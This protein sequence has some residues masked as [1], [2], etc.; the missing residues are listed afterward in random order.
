MDRDQI[1][2]QAEIVFQEFIVEEYKEDEEAEEG[3]ED[4]N[5][6]VFNVYN[7]ADCVYIK[8]S[9][10]I[11]ESNLITI[12]NIDNCGDIGIGNV[13]CRLIDV[14][15]HNINSRAIEL[16]DTSKIQMGKS[17]V[18]LA[19]LNTLKSGQTWYNS[20]GYMCKGLSATQHA[21]R[22]AKNTKF[23][24]SSLMNEIGINVSMLENIK[25]KNPELVPTLNVQ[26]YFVIVVGIFKDWEN[27]K[28]IKLLSSL[29]KKIGELN[30]LEME[31][32]HD[33]MIK[34]I[35]YVF[36][37]TKKR[38]KKGGHKRS[39]TKRGSFLRVK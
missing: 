28:Y 5:I 18:S 35:T 23:I 13:M 15:A 38:R 22:V 8:F 31:C 19:I 25:D 14:F 10:L 37:G 32:P 6:I 9:V 16:F 27:C 7:E 20:M 12:D 24:Q 33:A 4:P 17:S 11:I 1:I 34:K 2:K 26:S 3:E 30:V 36:G 21:A 29:I 39:K